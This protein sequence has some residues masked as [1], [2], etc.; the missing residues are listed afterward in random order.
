MNNQTEIIKKIRN[1]LAEL[2]ELK[3]EVKLELEDNNFRVNS[4]RWHKITVDGKQYLENPEKDIWEFL[5]D[6]FKG[7]QL[8][9]WKAAMR[10]TEKAGKRMPT[11]EEFSELVKT[12]EDIENIEFTGCRNTDGTFYYRTSSAGWW[13]SSSVYGGS[14]WE[15]HLGSSLATVGRYADSQFYGFSVRCLKK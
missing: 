2:E 10:E 6:E 7:E 1:L 5:D 11:D 3:H 12:K 9:T 15:R 8:F 4:D 13:S 14:A